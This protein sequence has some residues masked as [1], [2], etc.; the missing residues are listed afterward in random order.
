MK[1][2]PSMNRYRF[3]NRN[4]NSSSPQF[5]QSFKKLLMKSLPGIVLLALVFA[6]LLFIPRSSALTNNGT[7][8]TF[9]T[10]LTEN[11][12]TLASTGTNLIWTDNS[13]IPGW[14]SS[15]TTYTANNGSSNAGSL[16]S[17]GTGADRALGSVGSNATGDIFWGVRLVNSTGGTIN[18]LNISFVG[19][20]WRNGGNTTPQTVDFQYQV[21]NSGVITNI[22]SGTWTDFDPLDFTS[23]INT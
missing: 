16:Y 7:I 12:D 11:F 8:T 6:A 17:Y 19:E 22:T 14:Y 10:P 21:A 9:G 20:Q 4:L 13:T 15:R 18:S 23:L 5:D 3:K 1:K 2:I